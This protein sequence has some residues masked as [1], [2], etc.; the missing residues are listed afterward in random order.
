MRNALGA[1]PSVPNRATVP[2]AKLMNRLADESTTMAKQG[3]A[4]LLLQTR[5]PPLSYSA[6]MPL[7]PARYTLPAG[8]R[9]KVHSALGETSRSQRSV[10]TEHLR[11]HCAAQD[12]SAG[13]KHSPT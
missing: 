4:K 11:S 8:S 10:P 5:S 12:G 7:P 3:C 13:E 9:A 2:S 6:N 1:D